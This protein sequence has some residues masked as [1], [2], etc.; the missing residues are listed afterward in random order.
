M[1][2]GPELAAF[3]QQLQNDA[4]LR[5]LVDQQRRIDHSLRGL[6]KATCPPAIAAREEVS[7]TQQHAPPLKLAGSSTPH[8]QTRM[9]KRPWLARLAVAAV[10]VAGAYGVWTT[11]SFVSGGGGG[12]RL[13]TSPARTMIAYYQD[14]VDGG[15]HAYWKCENE[16]EFEQFY[17]KTFKQPLQMRP[18]PEKYECVGIDYARTFSRDT[19]AVLVNQPN[20]KVIVLID[21]AGTVQNQTPPLGCTLH[22]FT[23]D[24][25][26]LRLVEITPLTEP[27]ALDYFFDPDA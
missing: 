1:L 13:P 25:G 24:I 8:V 3:E 9:Q 27:T 17:R 23:R 22:T 15:F 12:D 6:M 11:W 2:S 16:Q 5:A 18:L 10:L 7:T 14:K 21:R 19:A 4:D 20:A 26:G